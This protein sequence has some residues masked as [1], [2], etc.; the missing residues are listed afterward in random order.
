MNT[1]AKCIIQWSLKHS[2]FFEKGKIPETRMI[3]KKGFCLISDG[4]KNFFIREEKGIE[5]PSVILKKQTTEWLYKPQI[6]G[7]MLHHVYAISLLCPVREAINIPW[8]Q[9]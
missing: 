2:S 7:W 3:T 9:C 4:K 6:I 5:I 8:T 1:E